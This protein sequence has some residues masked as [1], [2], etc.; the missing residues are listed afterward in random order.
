MTIGIPKGECF[1]L[2]GPNG[3][4]KTTLFDMISGNVSV[5]APTT[6][7]I[8][9]DGIPTSTSEGFTHAREMS[10]LAPQFDKI[11]PWVSARDHLRLY[12]KMCGTYDQPTEE[13]LETRRRK[14][15]A[16]IANLRGVI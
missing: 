5:G 8:Y 12:A 13:E 7:D 11:W 4:G 2:L 15:Q 10:G 6:G 14:Y 3:A 16:A 1:G 9:I